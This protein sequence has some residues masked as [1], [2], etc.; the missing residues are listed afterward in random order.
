MIILKDSLES[1]QLVL[2]KWTRCADALDNGKLLHIV[3]ID[4]PRSQ[5]A[6]HGPHQNCE[7]YSEW[8]IAVRH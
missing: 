3:T 7:R 4:F 5:P 6:T 1:S 8:I 2:Q